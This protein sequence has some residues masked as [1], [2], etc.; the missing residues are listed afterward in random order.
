MI[1]KLVQVP[2]WSNDPNEKAIH[3][4]S[5]ILYLPWNMQYGSSHSLLDCNKCCMWRSTRMT[6]VVIE[7]FQSE[8]PFPNSY[9]YLE[10]SVSG[11]DHSRLK[12][13]GSALR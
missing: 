10:I 6:Y 2:T 8:Q 3:K 9:Y 1:N 12:L 13:L 11:G 4:N 7:H 5:V